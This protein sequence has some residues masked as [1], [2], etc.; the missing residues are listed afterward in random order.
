MKGRG[1]IILINGDIKNCIYHAKFSSRQDA[2]H[3]KGYRKHKGKSGL[4]YINMDLRK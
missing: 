1:S 2:Q 3:E 4:W